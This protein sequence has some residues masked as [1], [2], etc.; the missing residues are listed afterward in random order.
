MSEQ[1]NREDIIKLAA[2]HG[3]TVTLSLAD[4]EMLCVDCGP[5]H[6]PN[7]RARLT[8]DGAFLIVNEGRYWQVGTK[9]DV[10]AWLKGLQ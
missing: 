2:E 3:K 5:A 6:D 4:P 8:S 7:E 9:N 1:M 10:E